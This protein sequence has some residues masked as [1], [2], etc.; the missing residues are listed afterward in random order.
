MKAKLY[1]VVEIKVK[2]PQ[3]RLIDGNRDIDIGTKGTIIEVFESPVEGYDVEFVNKEGYTEGIC[4][5][6]PED[7]DLVDQK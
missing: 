7:F 5:L 6:K 4:N 3:E 2:L 1:D